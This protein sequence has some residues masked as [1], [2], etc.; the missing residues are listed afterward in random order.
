[1]N[2]HRGIFM[3]MVIVFTLFQSVMIFA[4]ESASPKEVVAKVQ[5]AAEFL[6]KSG[7]AGVAEFMDRDGRWVWKDTYVWVLHCDE[8]TNAA[9]AIKP[10][11][12]GKKLMSIKDPKGRLFFAEFCN[13]AKNPDGGWVEYWWP[14]VGEKTP[15]RKITYILQV[16]GTPYQV[17]AGIYDETISIE[18]L[19]KLIQ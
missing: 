15:S 14:K 7:E 9:H 3:A 2:K 5:E 19:N 1:M 13:V 11:L 17:G 18:E 8:G 6:S 4:A 12:V 10:A 16:S